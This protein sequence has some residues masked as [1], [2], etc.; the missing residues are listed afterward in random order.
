MSVS[1]WTVFAALSV[2]SLVAALWLYRRLETPGRGR[3][4]LAVLRWLSLSLVLLLLFDPVVPVSGVPRGTA[5]QVL[6]DASASMRTP[7]RADG[8]SRWAEAAAEAVKVASG[9]EVLVFGATTR[10][11]AAESLAAMVPSAPTSRLLP[12]LQA[13]A[14][15]GVRRVTVLTDGQLDDAGEVR[16]WLPSLGIA[17]DVRLIGDTTVMNRSLMEVRAPPW[18][19]AGEPVD[20]EFGIVATGPAADSIRVVL[21]GAGQALATTAVPWPAAGRLSAGTVR[22]TPGS[23]ERGVVR[24]DV[25]IEGADGAAEDDVRSVYI[26]VGER[27]AGVVAVA[28]QPDW[29]LRFLQPVLERSLGLPVQ[30]Y[31]RTRDRGYVRTGTGLEVAT[32]VTEQQVRVAAAAADLLLLQGVDASSP[33]W[34]FEVGRNARR[35]LVL[36]AGGIDGLDIPVEIGRPS[37]GEWYPSADVPA[38]PVAPLLAGLRTD[39]AAPLSALSRPDVPR[40]SWAPLLATR[41]RRGEPAPIVVAGENGPRRWAVATGEGYWRW[42][43][44]GGSPG[45]LYA[46]LWSAVAGWLVRE[47]AAIAAAAVWPVTATIDAGRGPRWLAPGIEADS[48][49]LRLNTGDAE[50]VLDTVLALRRDTAAAA[51]VPPGEYRWYAQ[52]LRSDSAVAEAS[53]EITVET[54]SPD[55]SK[56][57][58]RLEDLRSDVTALSDGTTAGGRPLH[59]LPWPYLV[60]IGLVGAEWILRRRWGL[61]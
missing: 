40:G 37:A 42:A 7:A 26:R 48:L 56:P 55:F 53:G 11:V 16:R 14:E 41:G 13:A 29:E 43:F 58:V 59:A 22:F 38:S 21:T 52:A 9:R 50:T 47:Q 18:A 51:P 8:P 3:T 5:R 32:I 27:P 54:F 4:V 2:T 28:L 19:R 24:Y 31:L 6:I 34:I 33:S 1:I 30:G 60:L 44:R 15:A 12:A 35:L 10:A 57:R 36:P 45:E 61:R 20:V 25:R 49:V 39:E 17:V 23:G 46:R